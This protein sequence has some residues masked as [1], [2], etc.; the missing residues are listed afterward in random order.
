MMTLV[1]DWRETPPDV[2]VHGT[3]LRGLRGTTME[4]RA[5][6]ANPA[7][8]PALREVD[9][10]GVV[11][12]GLVFPVQGMCERPSQVL[13]VVTTLDHRMKVKT[14]AVEAA[15]VGLRAYL[16]EMFALSVAVAAF[17]EGLP[18]EELLGLLAEALGDLPE[19]RVQV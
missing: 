17:G 15:L 10:T 4:V 19:V 1:R 7:L 2:L 11:V 5:K 16:D 9:A 12:P 3:A 8:E 13:L 6:V 18:E 14:E